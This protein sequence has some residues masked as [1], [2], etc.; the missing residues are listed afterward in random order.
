MYIF[1]Y[2]HIDTAQTYVNEQDVGAALHA[3]EK[4]NTCARNELFVTTKLANTNLGRPH[5]A[6]SVEESLDNLKQKYVD[7]LLIHMPWGFARR[8]GE[9]N[10]RPM[11]PGSLEFASYDLNDTW[12]VLERLYKE[13]LV[14]SIGL[15]NFTQKQMEEIMANSKIKPHNVQFECHI[16]YQ[17]NVLRKFLNNKGIP[18]VTAYSPLG[19]PTRPERHVTP[20]NK[21]EIPLQDPVVND[22]AKKHN[23]TPALVLLRFVLQLNLAV[24]VKTTNV[25]RLEANLR[26]QDFDLDNKDMAKLHAL[27][28][29]VRFFVFKFLQSHPDFPTQGEFF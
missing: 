25:E 1:S 13:G 16:Y 4:H 15:S 19:A 21:F 7:L 24:V 28:R 20:K 29:N 9:N 3:V 2:R 6:H 17:Q 8:G 10:Y 22:I 27:D 11:L 23:V 18:S 12:S 26:V 14:K 5:I